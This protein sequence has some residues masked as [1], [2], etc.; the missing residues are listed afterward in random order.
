VIDNA[1]AVAWGSRLLDEPINP[2]D[3]P[4]NTFTIIMVTLKRQYRT[5]FIMIG[6][7]YYKQYMIVTQSAPFS[8]WK[9]MDPELIPK[10]EEG[11]R[12]AIARDLLEAEGMFTWS[13]TLLDALNTLIHRYY[14]I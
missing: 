10:F 11:Q 2:E 3:D 7:E 13:F 8:G 6:P 9:G 12:E 14:S 4:I 5:R 1:T